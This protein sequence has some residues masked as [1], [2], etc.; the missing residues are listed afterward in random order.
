MVELQLGD[1]LEL[2]R[3]LPSK[4]ID[5][6]V[7][8]PPYGKKPAGHFGQRDAIRF[9]LDDFD[10]DV[11][12]NADKFQEMFRASNNQIIWGANY[13]LDY[14]PPTNCILVWDK[15][16]GDNPYADVE[17]AWTSFTSASRIFRQF[18]LGAHIHR[19]EKIEHPTQK[20]RAL[21]E[22]CIL[23]YT[24]AGDTVLDPFMGSGTTGVACVKLQRNFI[25]MEINP[26]YFKIAERRIK[27]AQ[28]QIP[29]ELNLR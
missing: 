23:N 8:D 10:W 27:E 7:T 19:I 14:L 17:I 6:V 12:P 21:M 24:D 22:W 1:C 28:L 29:M 9:D 15:K 13:F 26:D 25:G 5:C 3:E 4:S 2:M 16:N 18:W 11:K 20:S